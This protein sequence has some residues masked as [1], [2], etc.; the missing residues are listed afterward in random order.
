MSSSSTLVGA[1]P[2]PSGVTPNFE[3]PTDVLRTVNYVTQALSILF[4]TIFIGLKHYAK[5][6]VLRGT[7]NLEDC[8]APAVLSCKATVASI[9]TD[10]RQTLLIF[11]TF[12]LSDT[13]ST[14]SLVCRLHGSAL[15]EK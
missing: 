9:I 15:T 2:A 10:T 12:S 3:E 6:S 11:H 7:W 14:A 5:S 4:V 8:K 13:A 1:A